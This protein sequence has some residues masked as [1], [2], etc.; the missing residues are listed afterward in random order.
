MRACIALSGTAI[1][2]MVDLAA[3]D[4]PIAPP[5]LP[6]KRDNL[7]EA[8]MRVI[9]SLMLVL[10]A[11]AGRAASSPMTERAKTDLV[12]QIAATLG[13]SGSRS[14]ASQ[15]VDDALSATSSGARQSGQQ[16]FHERLSARVQAYLAG[17]K[18]NDRAQRSKK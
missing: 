7:I 13:G 1:S 17:S 2:S 15:I 8:P 4:H 3:T 18:S 6:K 12:D 10:V 14:V 5:S 11:M 9:D 16:A